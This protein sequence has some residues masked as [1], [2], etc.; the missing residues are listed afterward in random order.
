MDEDF[1]KEIL[2]LLNDKEK[3][4]LPPTCNANFLDALAVLLRMK[5]W[6]PKDIIETLNKIDKDRYRHFR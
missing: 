2:D 4:L 3:A 5:G 1:L 6:P